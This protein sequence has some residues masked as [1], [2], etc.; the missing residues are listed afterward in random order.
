MRGAA[1]LMV[2]VA[3]PRRSLVR[4]AVLL[5]CPPERAADAVTDA[6]S[7]CR[8]DWG[9]ASREDDVD[10]LV[11]DELLAATARR[12]RTD[13]ASRQQAAHELLVLAPPTLD[14]LVRHKHQHDV[15]AR[16]RAAKVAVPLLLVAA[17][18]GAYL[19]TDHGDPPGANP[20]ELDR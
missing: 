20:D 17:G 8:G 10:Q 15:S 2:Y 1:D 19:A 18:V 11:R 4:E 5:G 12:P 3:A 13:G 14:D 7:R 6:L 16:R 9:R